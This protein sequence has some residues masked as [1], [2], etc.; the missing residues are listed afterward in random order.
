MGDKHGA[1]KFAG[2]T[3]RLANARARASEPAASQIATIEEQIA[4][5][6]RGDFDAALSRASLDVELEIFAPKEFPFIT[7]A[8]G[9]EKLRDAIQH[10]FGSVE[11]QQPVI[12]HIVAQGD[13]VVIFGNERGRVKSTGL[14][15][16]VEFVHRFT[17][18]EGAL[19]NIRI[20]VARAT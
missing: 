13:V 12:S 2:V 6:G 19:Q 4:A 1:K 14:P 20:I 8:R 11:D 9:P 7:R 17:F 15:Y 10:N 16:H 3:S 18:V 5:I